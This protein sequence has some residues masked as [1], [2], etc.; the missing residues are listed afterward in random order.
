MKRG[1]SPAN[2]PFA[3]CSTGQK[4]SQTM[5]PIPIDEVKALAVAW[6]NRH[7][8][9]CRITPAHVHGVGVVL[10]PIFVSQAAVPSASGHLTRNDGSAAVSAGSNT[11]TTTGTNANASKPRVLA[12][13]QHWARRWRLP[14]AAF[15]EDFLPP[16]APRAIARFAARHG[17]ADKSDAGFIPIRLIAI[18]V[19]MHGPEGTTATTLAVQT[20]AIELGTR[21]ERILLGSGRG[22]AALGRRIWSRARMATCTATILLSIAATSQIWPSPTGESMVSSPSRPIAAT[23]ISPLAGA[24]AGL[25]DDSAKTPAVVAAASAPVVAAPT[26]PTSSIV[27]PW[28]VNIRPR[29]DADTAR[30]AQREAAALRLA[31]HAKDSPLPV[32]QTLVAQGDRRYALVTRPTRSRLASEV[33]LGL[34]RTVA[35]KGRGNGIS[36]GQQTEILPAA[37]GWRASWWPFT[38]RQQAQQA[39]AV[40]ATVGLAAEV[41][42]F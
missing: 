15:S 34:M 22:G 19:A 37:Y 23:T 31:T 38:S 20:A 40:L 41:V 17:S 21:R 13:L 39:V 7:P 30:A 27:A 6:H 32:T 10:L 16:L 28:P 1:D 33:M 42:E 36:G 5:N 8:L 24:D 26:I 35:E 18:D 25:G 14:S 9:A 12:W 3:R 2:L 29:I 11:N 4:W